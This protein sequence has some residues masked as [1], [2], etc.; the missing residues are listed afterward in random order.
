MHTSNVA[1]VTK[2]D[3][4]LNNRTISLDGVAPCNQQEADTRLFLHA[5]NAVEE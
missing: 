2:E 3:G 5:K 4:V 1:I